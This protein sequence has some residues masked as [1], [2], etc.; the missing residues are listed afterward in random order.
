MNKTFQ[1]I[2]GGV[3]AVTA[4]MGLSACGSKTEDTKAEGKTYKVGIVQFVDDASLNQIEAAIEAELDAKAA[5][6][7]VTLLSK[8][9]PVRPSYS[10]LLPSG[11]RPA[12]SSASAM[13]LSVAPSKM[14]VATFQPRVL[15]A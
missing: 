14:G 13:S 2:V 9:S 15:A 12:S 4:L 7:G 1:K 3:L 8:R 11:S 6:L 5:E 10:Q